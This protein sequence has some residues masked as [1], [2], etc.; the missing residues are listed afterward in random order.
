MLL[1]LRRGLS[2]LTAD[3]IQL[4][5]HSLSIISFL[6]CMKKRELVSVNNTSCKLKTLKALSVVKTQGCSCQCGCSS[7]GSWEHVG[8]GN[9]PKS[10][11]IMAVSKSAEREKKKMMHLFWTLV[12]GLI[13]CLSRLICQDLISTH[14]ISRLPLFLLYTV[15]GLNA[16]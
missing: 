12:G 1:L 9:T 2:I 4:Q 11:L 7:L 13:Q 10:S 15:E 6:S 3:C 5:D 14:I 8:G 16:V